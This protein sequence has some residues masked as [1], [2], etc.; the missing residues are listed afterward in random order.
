[1]SQIN[2]LHATDASFSKLM[3]HHTIQYHLTVNQIFWFDLLFAEG[4]HLIKR[5]GI[6]I[7]QNHLQVQSHYALIFSL[8]LQIIDLWD[9]Q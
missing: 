6:D 8:F 9:S 7:R 3:H 4:T 1:M 5:K 2:P